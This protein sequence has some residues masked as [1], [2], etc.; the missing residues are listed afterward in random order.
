[1]KKVKVKWNVLIK[2]IMFIGCVLLILHD[3]YMMTIYRWINNSGVQI[4]WF[5]FVTL[6]LAV[7][8]VDLLYDDLKGELK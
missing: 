7:E 5:G 2:L 8:F 1:M 6:L 4:T 3:C